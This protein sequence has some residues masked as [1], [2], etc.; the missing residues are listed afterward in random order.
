MQPHTSHHSD[1][2]LPQG[3]TTPGSSMTLLKLAL[4]SGNR[5]AYE[6]DV[7]QHELTWGNNLSRALPFAA[8]DKVKNDAGWLELIHQD[9][10]QKFVELMN[11]LDARGDAFEIE[12]RLKPAD[13]KTYRVKHL[14][15][16][17]KKNKGHV[18]SVIGLIDIESDD[19]N[20]LEHLFSMS[21]T[22][23][24]YRVDC[25]ATET[26][27]ARLQQA[28]DASIGSGIPGGMLV[29]SV[30]N[31]GMII[32]SYGHQASEIVMRDLLR[33]IGG[34]FSALDAV[35]RIN[36][37][38]FGII[39]AEATRQTLQEIAY[40]IQTIIHNYGCD[41]LIN[42]LHVTCQVTS[43]DFPGTASSAQDAL[44]KAYIAMDGS[45]Q[46]T[47]RTFESTKDEAALWRQ[48]MGLANYLRK[49]MKENRLRLA[50]QPIIA[51]KDGSTSYYEALLRIAGD[52]G[53]ISSAGALIP[54]AETM[55][56]IDALDLS[57]LRMVV[58]E[59]TISPDV[60]LAFNISNLTTDNVR[61]LDEISKLVKD[62][63][64]IAQR[65][66]IEITETAAQRNL[67]KT[68]LFVASVQALGCQVALDDFGS[69]YTSFRQLK[70]LSV[71]IV[72]IDGAFIKD[73]A[74]NIDNRFF[75]K[76]LLDF[77]NAFGL[78]A[79]AEYVESGDTAKMLMELGVDYL[80]GYYFGRPM[81]QRVWLTQG[82][83]SRG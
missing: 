44:D 51:S 70:A 57:V 12:Y 80:Q 52:D 28:I 75:V 40:R 71:D 59:L 76:T 26:F 54:I 16:A 63:P 21:A 35:E 23:M 65:M 79:V 46:M 48:Q 64:E 82:E 22:T 39:I 45:K 20:S 4:N 50:F 66:I 68:A 60:I 72:K 43:I 55:G 56:L 19:K 61:W 81:N 25:H 49:A 10:R 24:S 18:E 7:D 31:L 77:T 78:K 33:L 5:V 8:Q 9:D 74:D 58:E 1:S 6:W 27:M 37:D 83:Y 47:Y 73:L 34:A 42:A 62:K 32:N 11:T 13:G 29:V 14:G 15:A 36:R 53:K 41:S 30:S 2:P 67:A 38:Q 69:G 3:I 17:A